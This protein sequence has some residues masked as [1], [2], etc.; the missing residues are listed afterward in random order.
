MNK[1]VQDY[2]G[3]NPTELELLTE[4]VF[5]KINDT[6]SYKRIEML[7][8][9]ENLDISERLKI[10]MSMGLGMSVAL[11]NILDKELVATIVEKLNNQI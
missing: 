3:L 10:W 8:I 5:N 9:I 1:E 11:E 6:K 4:E 7:K 2:T